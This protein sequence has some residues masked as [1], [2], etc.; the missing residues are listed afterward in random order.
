MPLDSCCLSQYSVP[1]S[2]PNLIPPVPSPCSTY[3]V[4]SIQDQINKLITPKE[5]EAIIRSL[6]TRKKNPGQNANIFSKKNFISYFLFLIFLLC[7][8]VEGGRSTQQATSSQRTTLWSQFLRSF[9]TRVSG[10][11]LN[12][13]A[14]MASSLLTEPSIFPL[15]K[16]EVTH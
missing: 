6:P 12:K 5:T 13:Q 10:I 7:P 8:C 14:C 4:Y 2:S 11:T 16:S 1:A 3:N 9:S 15:K